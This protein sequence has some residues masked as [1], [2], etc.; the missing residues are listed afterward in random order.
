[1]GPEMLV[2]L[3]LVKP[4]ATLTLKSEHEPERGQSAGGERSCRE[5]HTPF[6]HLQN[7][8]ISGKSCHLENGACARNDYWHKQRLSG[9]SSHNTHLALCRCKRFGGFVE[10]LNTCS[11]LTLSQEWWPGSGW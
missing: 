5:E 3:S 9:Y 6:F 4:V 10:R 1:M 7:T 11:P 8:W 2:P